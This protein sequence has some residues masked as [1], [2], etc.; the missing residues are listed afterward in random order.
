[1]KIS[2][3]NILRGTITSVNKG[4]VNG[5]VTLDCGG[6]IIKSD[7]T[8]EAIESLDLKVGD[9]AM[10]VIKSTDVMMAID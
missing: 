1:M 5:I 4:A 3:R 7:I 9:E 10:A 6:N 8:N 2:A